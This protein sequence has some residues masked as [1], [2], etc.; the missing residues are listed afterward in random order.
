MKPWEPAVDAFTGSLTANL[1]C[2]AHAERLGVGALSPRLEA[3]I[4]A[5]RAI[6]R[7]MG[8]GARPQRIR[9]TD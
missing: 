4:V 7:A 2:L 1:S 8:W 3:I 5:D 6:W 9:P